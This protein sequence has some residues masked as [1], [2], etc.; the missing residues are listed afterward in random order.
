ME[1]EREDVPDHLGREHRE[2]GREGIRERC[3]VGLLVV[4]EAAR[5]DYLLKLR[6]NVFDVIIIASRATKFTQC[7]SDVVSAFL[8]PSSVYRA[9]LK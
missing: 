6:S 8:R 5:V 4:L 2:L 9:A 1:A 3:E 7:L